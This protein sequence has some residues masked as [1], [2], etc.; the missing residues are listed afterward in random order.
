M[1]LS[2][3]LGLTLLITVA[4]VQADLG[5]ELKERLPERAPTFFFVDIQAAQK[6]RF[7]DAVTGAGGQLINEAPMVRGRISR[8]DGVPAGQVS[9]RSEAQWARRGDRGLSASASPPPDTHIVAGTW[10]APDY[11]GPPLVSMDEGIAR[12]FGIGV[13]H[14]VTLNVL[15]RDITATVANLRQIEWSSMAMNFTFILDPNA[16]KGA[17]QN[18][19]A[20]VIAPPGQENAVE[21]AVGTQLPTVSAIRV[22]TALDQ[23]RQFVDA[24][25][26]ALRA[27]ALVALA[28]GVLVLSA[29]IAASQR[30]RLADIVVLKVLGARQRDLMLATGLEYGLIGAAASLAA[31]LLGSVAA[32]AVTVHFLHVE[33][34]FSLMPMLLVAGAAVVL[35]TLAGLLG[36]WRALQ[37][38][39]RPQM[40]AE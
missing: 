5:E 12:G 17:P 27:A 32:W 6:D 16:L 30:Q 7:D 28:S 40:A 29:A 2:L 34:R 14:T 11:A 15:G 10:W 4:L 19:I 31:G 36:T 21:R 25:A 37:A 18:F 38:P 39:P 24:L 33:W 26:L 20:T 8:I 22:K 1:V 9:I 35:V 3:G 23:V 13:G